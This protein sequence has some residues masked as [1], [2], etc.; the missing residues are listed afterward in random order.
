MYCYEICSRFNIVSW[1]ASHF[2]FVLL[3]FFTRSSTG[4]W[5]EFV[6]SLCN[7]DTW[8]YVMI[9]QRLVHTSIHYMAMKLNKM[10]LPG[11]IYTTSLGNPLSWSP[12]WKT[13]KFVHISWKINHLPNPI[14]IYF[15]YLVTFP[16]IFCPAFTISFI[17]HSLVRSV[18]FPC[19]SARQS[20][21][22]L[23]QKI[24]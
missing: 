5:I 15:I 3:Y 11:L 8:A 9:T 24:K 2:N 10:P 13:L 16:A 1:S 7:L 17:K 12:L 21:R 19:Y 18:H 22:F 20:L 4:F 23:N 14:K 6:I